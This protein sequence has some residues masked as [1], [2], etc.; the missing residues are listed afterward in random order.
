MEF[1]TKIEYLPMNTWFEKSI[2]KLVTYRSPNKSN[3]NPP[4]DM[5]N[6]AQMDFVLINKPWKNSIK[7]IEA[8][9]PSAF[10]SDHQPIT[11]EMQVK[12]AN[13]KHKII[14]DKPKRYRKPTEE[15]DNKI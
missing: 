3:F 13:K 1:C 6:F 10:D 8:R 5:N 12:L 9:I 11:I 7:D 14:Q 15:E 4:F 2:E